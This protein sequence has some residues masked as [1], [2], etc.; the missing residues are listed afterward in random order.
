MGYDEDSSSL[1]MRWVK[2]RNAVKEYLS[3]VDSDDDGGDDARNDADRSLTRLRQI[4]NETEGG[5]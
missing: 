2:M 3:H 1:G 4:F 5:W